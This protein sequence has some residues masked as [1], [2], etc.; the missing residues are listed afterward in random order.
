MRSAFSVLHMNAPSISLRLVK[1]G[2]EYFVKNDLLVEEV[3]TSHW[4]VTD[5][6]VAQNVV[7]DK[8]EKLDGSSS[9]S[10]E[11]PT[12]LAESDKLLEAARAKE[13]SVEE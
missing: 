5:E 9:A 12:K 2:R 11:L 10:K 8:L 7:D 3:G 1:F 6:P 4:I 13:T